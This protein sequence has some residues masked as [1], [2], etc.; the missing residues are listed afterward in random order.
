M[1][2]R[3]P[4]NGGLDRGNEEQCE[5]IDD[6]FE[7]RPT[8]NEESPNVNSKKRKT[9]VD[10]VIKGITLA[11]NILGEKLEKAANSM[12]QAIIGETEVQKKASMVI[13]E[14][15]NWCV[16]NKCSK[17]KSSRGKFVNISF[18]RTNSS[19]HRVRTRQSDSSIFQLLPVASSYEVGQQKTARAPKAA[20]APR[21]AH[22]L[23]RG[24]RSKLR[25]K[26][27][28]TSQQQERQNMH[29]HLK[30]TTP[31]TSIN[32]KSSTTPKQLEFQQKGQE[33][34]N[35]TRVIEPEPK[36]YRKHV[37]VNQPKVIFGK[38]YMASL[39]GNKGTFGSSGWR[40]DDN[41]KINQILHFPVTE[42]EQCFNT[43]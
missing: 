39:Q 29:K 26:T 19:L 32:A 17:C 27:N 37:L 24:P 25:S 3:T 22:Q 2:M 41:L 34:H 31:S 30:T 42:F 4:Q 18:I 23:N 1:K 38:M 13:P 21:T 7:E 10:A 5:Q 14:I 40:I 33:L 20:T 6:D 8:E 36:L 35:S 15:S 28:G 11:T 9:R 16:V 43:N 12:N